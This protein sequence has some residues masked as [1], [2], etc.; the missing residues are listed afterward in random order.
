[1]IDQEGR[2][3]THYSHCFDYNPDKNYP[4][5]VVD[6]TIGKIYKCLNFQYDAS[7]DVN[8]FYNKNQ[9]CRVCVRYKEINRFK[10]DYSVSLPSGAVVTVFDS[11]IIQANLKRYIEYNETP[12]DARIFFNLTIKSIDK[13]STYGVKFDKFT[14]PDF[15][16][17]KEYLIQK[18]FIDS[19]KDL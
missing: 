19:L 18:N 12:I 1:M 13:P 14:I 9:H 5:G 2:I 7:K 3:T 11:N 15:I 6:Q 16:F 4:T 17:L 10:S 8:G